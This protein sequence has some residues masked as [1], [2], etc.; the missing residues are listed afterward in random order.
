MVT[1][2]C[3]ICGIEGTPSTLDY[4]WSGYCCANNPDCRPPMGPQKRVVGELSSALLDSL[5][6]T[7][8]HAE[9]SCTDAEVTPAVLRALVD[10]AR[11]KLDAAA[12]RLCDERRRQVGSEVRA[13]LYQQWA[14]ED[15]WCTVQRALW[16]MD[17]DLRA[18]NVPTEATPVDGEA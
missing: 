16:A 14:I 5:E 7:A 12:R 6:W 18:R 4:G 11:V 17:P 8:D 2:T 3:E 10:V 15:R 9:L 13:V 1:A